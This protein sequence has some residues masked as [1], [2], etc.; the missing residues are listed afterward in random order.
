MASLVSDFF[1]KRIGGEEGK[2][3]AKLIRVLTERVASG[4]SH[5]LPAEL[6]EVFDDWKSLPSIGNEEAN[7]PLVYTDTGRLYFRRYYEYERLVADVLTNKCTKASADVSKTT[8]TFFQNSIAHFVDD[9]Q[10]LAV[11]AVLQRDLVLLSGGP[12]TGKT[13]LLYTSPSPRD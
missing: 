8:E 3:L 6:N 5:L 2:S 4:S 13:C 11:G 1:D 12:G 9:Q 7:L 10:A